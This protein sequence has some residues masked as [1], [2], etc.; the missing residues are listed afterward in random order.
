MKKLLYQKFLKDTFK[1]FVIMTFSIGLIVW[2]IQAVNFLDFVTEDGHGLSVYFQYT[3][4][5]L[6]K[7]LHRILPFVFFISLFY[8]ISQYEKKNELLI[9]WTNGISKLNFTNIVIFYSIA[10]TLFQIVLGS[11]I[12][13]TSQRYAKDFLRTSNID[14]LPSLIKEGK[15]IDTVKNLTIFIEKKDESGAYKN[16]FLKD[17]MSGNINKDNSES[18]IVYAKKGILIVN[19]GSKYF[20]LFNGYILNDSAGSITTISFEKIDFNLDKYQ[21]KTTK[22]P[23]IQEINTNILFKCIFHHYKGTLGEFSS[24]DLL[25][26]NKFIDNVKQEFL[27]RFYKPIYLPLL[28]LITCL[29]IFISKENRF[30][31]KFKTILFMTIFF[32]IVFSETSLRYVAYG[33]S[34]LILFLCFPILSI[35]ILYVIIATKFNNRY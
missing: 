26:N 34:G 21:S 16:I 14:Y 10:I 17:S 18:Q 33:Q 5:N 20:R 12:S 11:Y 29:L 6:P 30:Y 35:L 31:E 22:A 13:P 15:F 32:I 1:F 23:K 19:E 8:Q 7:I 28:A 27:K 2:V 9:F 3:F 24:K 25:C 4:L